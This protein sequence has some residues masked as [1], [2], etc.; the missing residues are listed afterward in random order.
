MSRNVLRVVLVSLACLTLFTGCLLP[1]SDHSDDV[2]EAWG[3]KGRNFHRKWDRY[4]LGLDW[5]DPYHEWHDPSYASGPMI[6]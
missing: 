3:R 4:F 2:L 5:D 1:F 6:R